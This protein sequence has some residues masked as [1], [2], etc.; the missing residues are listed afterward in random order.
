MNILLNF[1]SFTIWREIRIVYFLPPNY[2]LD[3]N[4]YQEQLKKISEAKIAN[5]NN[6]RLY[7]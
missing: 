4:R 7:L 1:I 5:T 6:L 2:Q 3:P